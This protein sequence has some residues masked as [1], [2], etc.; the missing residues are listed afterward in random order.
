MQIGQLAESGN[1]PIGNRE[2]FVTI[3]QNSLGREQGNR[4]R[5]SLVVE[6]VVD[7]AAFREM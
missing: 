4:R 7:A 5:Q 3:A 1:M 2:L 6:S